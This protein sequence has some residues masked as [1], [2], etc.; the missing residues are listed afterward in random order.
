MTGAMPDHLEA[1]DD[2]YAISKIL[3]AMWSLD[4]DLEGIIGLSEAMGFL[5]RTLENR[6]EILKFYID[7]GYN[8]SDE[9]EDIDDDDEDDEDDSTDEE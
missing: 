7:N 1:L 3:V 2:L 5:A 6:T 8:R 4:E 9:S